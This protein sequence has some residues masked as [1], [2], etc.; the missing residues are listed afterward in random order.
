VDRR[1]GKKTYIAK[2]E[3][4]DVLTVQPELRSSL[5]EVL[6]CTI[7]DLTP[8]E[9]PIVPLHPLGQLL[10]DLMSE[11]GRTVEDFAQTFFSGNVTKA[12]LYI[13]T[14]ERIHLSRAGSFA[15]YF[16]VPVGRFTPMFATL[17]KP[18][19]SALGSVV[20]T[21]RLKRG[22]S[23]EKLGQSVGVTRELIRQVEVGIARLYQGL[24]LAQ[25]IAEALAIPSEEFPLPP[26]P[27][28]RVPRIRH[29]TSTPGGC[30]VQYRLQRQMTQKELAA[31]LQRP[32]T[33]IFSI[34]RNTA[35]AELTLWAA[36]Q[37]GLHLPADVQIELK[38]RPAGIGCTSD[39]WLPNARIPDNPLV[40]YIKRL[41]RNAS[42]SKAEFRLRADMTQH[43]L[44]TILQNRRCRWKTVKQMSRNL[45]QPIP[46]DVLELL[47][48]WWPGEPELYKN[49]PTRILYSEKNT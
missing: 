16:E 49:H 34:E 8:P 2:V 22:W 43:T 5:A 11:S 48:A 46:E 29:S 21:Y 44:C 25:K 45:H 27:K 4:G 26:R 35:S 9:R 20:R 3:I 12:Q 15:E 47:L 23:L 17:C 13:R 30:F 1:L 36:E 14:A 28:R 39:W 38:A 19:K 10:L 31:V 41:A 40:Q 42:M 33:S 6:Q 37:I 24:P 18:T 7:A 32:I